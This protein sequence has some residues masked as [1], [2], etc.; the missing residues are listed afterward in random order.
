[1]KFV[2]AG[3]G[4]GGHVVPA[5]AVAREAAGR[6]H[7]VTFIGTR[8]GIEAKLVPE[9]GF[10]IEWIEI[11]G[12]KRVGWKKLMQ[13]LWQLPASVTRCVRILDRE[14]PAAVFSMGGYV[15][16]PAVLGAVWRRIPVVAME[17]N[18]M[19]GFV[20]RMMARWI[21]RALLG[22]EDAARFFPEGRSEVTGVPVREP[23]F[24]AQGS[25]S[26]VFTVL[27]TGGSQGSRTLNR[28]FRE[29]WPL[30]AAQGPAVRFLHQAGAAEA[31]VLR[32]DFAR[33]GLAGSVTAFIADM[34]AAFAEARLVVGR[35][36]AG[37]VAELAAAGKPSILVPF[38]HAADDHQTANARAMEQAGAALCVA[39]GEFTGARL[40]REVAALAG[41]AARL[42]RMGGAAKRLARPGAA[43]RAVTA[44]EQACKTVPFPV[45][46]ERESRNN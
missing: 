17:P 45:D 15:A 10:P 9:A 6:G 16:G 39:D 46:T 24:A 2:F 25:G 30:F 41:D 21:E 11:G 29:S 5:L 19:P 33:T 37:A 7:D 26:S 42:A 4:T 18:A 38:P 31:D 22:M 12:M 43:A 44:L 20:H 13:S 23:F 3:G 35:A 8:E 36:G 32:E 34:P 1:M 28:A 14:R 40:H 27:I